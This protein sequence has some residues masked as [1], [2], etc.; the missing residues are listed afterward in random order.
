MVLLGYE[1]LKAVSSRQ[2]A[3]LVKRS[4]AIIIIIVLLIGYRYLCGLAASCAVSWDASRVSKNDFWLYFQSK[5]PAK[6]M[7]ELDIRK[8]PFK[9]AN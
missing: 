5:V 4:V 8:T 6:S 2:I 9:I 7:I 1:G 3:R